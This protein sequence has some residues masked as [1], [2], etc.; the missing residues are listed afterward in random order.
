[1]ADAKKAWSDVGDRLSALGLKLKLHTEEE[2]SEGDDDGGSGL[3]KL[4]RSI[5]EVLDAIGDAARDPAVR[6]DAKS[7]GTAF[8]DAIDATVEEARAKLRSK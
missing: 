8:A 1:M 4:K 2:R 3:E 5:N 6:D 7:V